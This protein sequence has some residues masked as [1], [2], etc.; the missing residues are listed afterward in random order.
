M[1]E[2]PLRLKQHLGRRVRL[3]IFY[4]V[5]T[6]VDEGRSIIWTGAMEFSARMEEE[7]KCPACR[8]LYVRPVQLPGCWHSLCYDCAAARIQTVS[9]GSLSPSASSLSSLVGAGRR[10]SSTCGRGDDAASVMTSATDSSS[11][12]DS[13][14]G[15]SVVSE[16]DSGVVAGSGRP[17]SSLGSTSAVADHSGRSTQTIIGC[18]AC[19]RVVV[20]DGGVASL[21]PTRALDS[22]VERYRE[23]RGLQLDCQLCPTDT[24]SSSE[25]VVARLATRICSDC[26][27]CICDVCVHSD[28]D[29]GADHEVTSLVD[30]RRQLQV[31]R[32]ASDA[33][34]S[35]H[36][37]ESRSLY[38]LVCRA[39]VCC[40]CAREG[41][42]VGHHTQPMGAMCKAQKVLSPTLY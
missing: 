34:C 16:S 18:P 40:V 32:M 31:R 38:C 5:P 35:D 37:N 25:S 6:A 29:D 36:H 8:R 23:A 39:T 2:R 9:A 13:S 17:L 24:S 42:H 12:H 7:L 28:P 10:S 21:P 27:L 15:L 4:D 1:H 20:V 33:R 30:G 19:S 26:E 22:I 14:D 3:I 41:R 11:E